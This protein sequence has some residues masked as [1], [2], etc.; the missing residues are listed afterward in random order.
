MSEWVQKSIELAVSQ[1]YLNRLS[2]IYPATPFPPRPLDENIRKRIVALHQQ[3][4]W[5]KLLG[6]LFEQTKHGHPFPIEHPYASILRQ[7]PKLIESNPKMVQRLGEMLLSM[8]VEEILRGTERAI[9]INRVMGSAF[10]NWLRR[11][12]PSQGIPILPEYKFESYDGIAF[13]D[14]KNAAIL[15]YVNRKLGHKL[16]RGRDFLVKVADKFVVG[17][18]RFLSTSGGSQTRDLKETIEFIRS[19]KG[20]IMAVGILDGIVWFNRSYVTRLLSLKD[21]EHALTVLL[22]KDFLKSLG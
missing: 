6:V 7:K 15:N 5:Q 3:K 1:D 13:L 11:Y 2:Q 22:L 10:H 16:E 12:F 8:S 19:T 20:K 21:D 9:D 17:E 4:D 14:A 18:A